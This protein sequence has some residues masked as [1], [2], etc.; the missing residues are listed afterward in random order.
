MGGP[1]KKIEQLHGGVGQMWIFF[2]G[3]CLLLISRW[4][5]PDHFASIP[6]V[7]DISAINVGLTNL[8]VDN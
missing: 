8:G 2:L 1:T 4:G 5:E 7:P 6:A 3:P